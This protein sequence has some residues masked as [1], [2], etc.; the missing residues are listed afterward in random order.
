[1]V[2]K[3]KRGISLQPAL[4]LGPIQTGGPPPGRLGILAMRGQRFSR[5][6]GPSGTAM[7]E[8]SLCLSFLGEGDLIGTWQ[9]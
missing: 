3:G 1:M 6:E 5:F 7:I 4:G 2:L 8:L 9:A